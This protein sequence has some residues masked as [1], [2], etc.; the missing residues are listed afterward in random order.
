VRGKVHTGVVENLREENT[1]STHDRWEDNTKMDHQEVGWGAWAGSM[2]LRR[3][4]GG[5]HV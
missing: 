3:G 5:G 1:W 4:T 2:W